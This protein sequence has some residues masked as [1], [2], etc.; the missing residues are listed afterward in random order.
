MPDGAQA[1]PADAGRGSGVVDEILAGL[2]GRRRTLPAKLFYDEEGCRL[3]ERI[4]KLDAYYVTRAERALLQVNAADIVAAAPADAL[5]EYGAADETKAEY[6]LRHGHYTRY[7]PIDIAPSA[8]SAIRLRLA[9]ARP[10]L[11]VHPLVADFTQPFSRPACLEG[12]RVAGFFPGSTI[13]NF[14]PATVVSFLSCAR[15]TLASPDGRSRFIVG[16]DLRKEA[17]RLLPAYDDPQGVTAAFNLNILAHVNLLA[18]ADFD[19]A[20]FEHRAIFDETQSR[21]EMH[22]VSK[23]DQRVM[24]A[25]RPFDFATGDHIHTE[26]SYKHSREGFLALAGRAG[27]TGTGF[28]TDPDRL[29]GVHLLETSS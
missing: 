16:T 3:F 29:F 10:A 21:I 27:W 18:D 24:V 2:S 9:A 4:T 15:M 7:I 22:L 5:V 1:V 23:R 19:L 26:N 14:E 13:G 6:L 28:W 12:A 17:S 8:L 20:A 25:G 11:A